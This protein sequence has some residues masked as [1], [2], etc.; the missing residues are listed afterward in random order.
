MIKTRLVRYAIWLGTVLLYS[1]A[2]YHN[3]Y[4]AGEVNIQA[5]WDKQTAQ[6]KSAYEAQLA[7][8]KL[9]EDKQN[10]IN[11]KIQTDY[12]RDTR[13]LAERLRDL[14]PS[15]C[16]VS[17]AAKSTTGTTATAEAST[18]FRASDALSDTLQCS[19]LIEWV[20]ENKLD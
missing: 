12:N 9:I 18:S 20:K 6:L 15:T 3:G 19:K 7:A 2:V 10:A 5:Q 17:E 4:K 1:F 16:T 8:S 14:P 11:A 13:I